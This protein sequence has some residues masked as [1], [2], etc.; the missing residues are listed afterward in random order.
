MLRRLTTRLYDNASLL[1]SFMAL[2]WAGNQVPGR[3]IA[4]HIYS[5]A[6]VGQGRASGARTWCSLEH[7]HERPDRGQCLRV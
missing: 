1:L 5:T 6:S 4:G 2:C 3:A 7:P